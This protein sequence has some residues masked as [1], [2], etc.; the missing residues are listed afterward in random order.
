MSSLYFS[1]GATLYT[2][3]THDKLVT[4]MRQG[5][6]GVRS[7][8]F[9]TEDA[10]HSRD[11]NAALLNISEAL[12]VVPA[13][14]GFSRFIRPR[15]PGVLSLLLKDPNIHKVD[16]F[17]LPKLDTSNVVDY[18][19]VLGGATHHFNVMPILESNDVFD[20]SKV[21]LI[22]DEMSSLGDQLICFRVGANDL[23]GSIGLKRMRGQTIYETPLNHVIMNLIVEVR[24][25]GFELAA[26]VFDFIE[27]RETLDREVALDVKY[28]LY[29]KTAIHP[30]QVVD[31]EKHYT[32]SAFELEKAEM[33]RTGSDE[34]IFLLNGQMCEQSCHSRWA[35]RTLKTASVFGARHECK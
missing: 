28:G 16:G 15:N 3:A 5:L 32:V 23:L 31:I 27:D 30:T 29:S 33:L 35:E 26:P 2:P 34:A 11:V 6:A 4:I 20:I 24:S 19:E 22:V 13:N 17:V 14:S 18:L 25:R 8:V 10:V 1:L 7:V 12:A 9:C 21:R